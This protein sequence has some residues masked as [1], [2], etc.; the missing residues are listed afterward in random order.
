MSDELRE[1]IFIEKYR[2]QKI[3]DLILR[4]K[5][6]IIK[7]LEDNNTIPNLLL[8]SNKPGTGKTSLAK[9]IIKMT[10]SD[11]ITINAS[12]ERGIDTIRDKVKT[13]AGALSSNGKRRCVFLDEFEGTT[14][15]AQDSLKSIIETYSDNCF[16]IFTANFEEKIIEPIK[17]RCITINFELPEKNEILKRLIYI[18]EQEDLKVTD[19]D[20]Q[21]LVDYNFPDIRSM[22]N[23]LQLWKISNKIEFEEDRYM[24][25]WTKIK[26]KN[27]EYVYAES[28]SGTF[29]IL[30][31]TKFLF[32]K[33]FDH[34]EKYG[35]DKTSQIAE[36]IAEVEK[37]NNLGANLEIIFINAILQ[38]MKVL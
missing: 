22:V 20:L 26:E 12:D 27:V 2:P 5:N 33:L 35:L 19:D 38:I 24:Q 11:S 17:S 6:D 28:Y 23:T 1:L 15:Q 29:R 8:V 18:C 32:E 9:L 10:N 36:Q 31:F 25:M 4:N 7:L 16:F 13:F 14:R 37:H 21:R 3:E 30:E 34:Y